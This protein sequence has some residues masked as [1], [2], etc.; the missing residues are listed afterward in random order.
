MRGIRAISIDP[1]ARSITAIEISPETRFCERLLRRE[2][3]SGGE[4]AKG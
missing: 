2:A 1:A 4:A 3:E